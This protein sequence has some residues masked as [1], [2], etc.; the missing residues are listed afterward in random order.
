MIGTRGQIGLVS[1]NAKE[2]DK[3][4]HFQGSDVVA[5]IRPVSNT[6]RHYSIIGSGLI[7][8]RWGE[9]EVPV[10]EGPDEIFHYSV[11]QRGNYSA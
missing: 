10:F 6:S 1:A 11:G 8:R 3:I 2:G 7:L 5:T 4:C 9:E